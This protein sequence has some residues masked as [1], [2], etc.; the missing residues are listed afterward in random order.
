MEGPDLEA[1]LASPT[2]EERLHAAIQKLVSDRQKMVQAIY[3]ENVSVN[4]YL[5]QKGK[6]AELAL[7]YGGSEGALKAMGALNY[8]LSEEALKPLQ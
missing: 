5:R 8:G 7:G 2:D 3:F 6:V 1:L 4:G